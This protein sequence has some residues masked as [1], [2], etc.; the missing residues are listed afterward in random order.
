MRLTRRNTTPRARVL[1]QARS[2]PVSSGLRCHRLVVQKMFWE[3]AAS[4]PAAPGLCQDWLLLLIFASNPNKELPS[5]G[6]GEDLLL[7]VG[8]SGA[9]G[10]GW[11]GGRRSRNEGWEARRQSPGRGWRE[12]QTSLGRRVLELVGYAFPLGCGSGWVINACQVGVQMPLRYG[13]LSVLSL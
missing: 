9:G 2:P 6:G 1:M 12:V 5:A 7:E 3:P 8:Q 13:A 10:G 4:L 11:V